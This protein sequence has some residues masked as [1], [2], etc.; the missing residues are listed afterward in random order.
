MDL[1]KKDLSGKTLHLV[2]EVSDYEIESLCI[3]V[4]VCFSGPDSLYLPD[5][6]GM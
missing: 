3:T 1:I 4:S 5:L 2:E 6:L